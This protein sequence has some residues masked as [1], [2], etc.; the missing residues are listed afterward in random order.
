MIITPVLTLILLNAASSLAAPLMEPGYANLVVRDNYETWPGYP[1]VTPTKP[2]PVQPS[3]APSTYAATGTT[4][5][6]PV[7]APAG[8]AAPKY[9]AA[10]PPARKGWFERLGSFIRKHRA[11]SALTVVGA[12][13]LAYS[14]YKSMRFGTRNIDED[15]GHESKRSDLDGLD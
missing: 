11:V 14:G 7:Q 1:D 2:P 6:P 15:Y 8:P 12:G 3:A 13:T 9:P 5:P 4:T 10:S